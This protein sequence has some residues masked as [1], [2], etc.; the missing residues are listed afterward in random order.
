MKKLFSRLTLT[1][2]TL[3]IAVLALGIT[4]ST[5]SIAGDR[6]R[7]NRHVFT[8]YARVLHVEPTYRTVTRRTPQRT[9]HVPPGHRQNPHNHGHYRS[10]NRQQQRRHSPEAVFVRGVI[11]G[12]IGH[13]LTKSIN[14]RS[15]TGATLAGAAIGA[16]LVAAHQQQRS[17]TDKSYGNNR[18]YVTSTQHHNRHKQGN[19]H[20]QKRC[21]TTEHVQRVREISGYRVTYR[22]RGRTFHTHTDHHPGDKIPVRVAVST[23]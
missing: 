1:D 21:T 13:E 17:Y 14:G 15:N 18:K 8:D 20:R 9:C 16:G 22:F 11:G 3:R 12:A 2:S 6:H 7:D 19:H 4:A 23:H 5:G 10:H